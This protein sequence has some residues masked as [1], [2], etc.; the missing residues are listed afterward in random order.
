MATDESTNEARGDATGTLVKHPAKYSKSVINLIHREVQRIVNN[1]DLGEWHVL[2]PFGGIGG[3]FDLHLMERDYEPGELTFKIT[4]IEI[5]QEWAEA[6]RCHQRYRGAHDSAL[7]IDFFD[8]ANHPSVQETFDLV[9][10]SPTY[11]NRM[12]DHHEAR[13][14][15][16]RNTYRHTLGRELTRGSSA[17]MQWGPEYRI[18]HHDA[19]EMVYKLLR[20]GGYFLLNVKDHIRQ[21][22]KQP[23]AAWH[24]ATCENEGFQLRLSFECPVGGN[25]QG[26]NHEVRVDHEKVYLF[27]R[28]WDV[29]GKTGVEFG[30]VALR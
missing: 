26:E 9:I 13:D 27:Q 19:W 20:P 14:D 28:P 10:V 17:G 25:R 24:K 5:E 12:A 7:H 18:F 15:S 4:N 6:A 8:Y 3:I 16:K 21:G 1:G 23:V 22:V 2:D 29:G 11:G 30:Q